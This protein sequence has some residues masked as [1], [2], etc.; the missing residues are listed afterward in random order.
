MWSVVCLIDSFF[1]PIYLGTHSLCV[2]KGEGK[3]NP[4]IYRSV[5]LSVYIYIH[6]YTY[7][8]IHPQQNRVSK[9]ALRNVFLILGLIYLS[10]ITAAAPRAHLS[11][12]P[13]DTSSTSTSTSTSSSSSDPGFVYDKA[14]RIRIAKNGDYSSSTYSDAD[15]ARIFRGGDP[16][17]D[18]SSDHSPWWFGYKPSTSSRSR[19]TNI[20]VAQRALGPIFYEQEVRFPDTGSS[21]W[22]AYTDASRYFR[23]SWK[24]QYLD[25]FDADYPLEHSVFLNNNNNNNRDVDLALGAPAPTS[26][27]SI[28]G[29]APGTYLVC[30]R[31][32]EHIKDDVLAVRFAYA[33]AYAG[34]NE[35][36]PEN[37][38]AGCVP[39]KLESRCAA[40]QPLVHN[41]TW[42]HEGIID[43]PCVK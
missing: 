29:R 17:P 19:F 3:D 11:K 33:Y 13:R 14:Y 42:N 18:S 35:T 5:Y 9:M 6:T 43:V 24:A 27:P 25:E 26:P 40:L 23:L 37:I 12:G 36:E 4:S 31:T 32:Y 1:L 21:T 7:T 2:K 20:A 15:Y 22:A 34:V 39:V 30:R 16:L 10:T 28:W 38:P 8:Y 41:R